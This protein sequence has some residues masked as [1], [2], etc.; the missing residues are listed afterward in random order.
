MQVFDAVEADVDGT[1]LDQAFDTLFATG[2]DKIT[3]APNIDGE[4]A[5]PIGSRCG[6]STH[7][8]DVGCGVKHR[9]DALAGGN[10]LLEVLY[11]TI[12]KAEIGV[13]QVQWCAA[14][15]RTH[16]VAFCQKC[17]NQ[18]AAGESRSACYQAN[19]Q[20]PGR[21]AFRFG[22]SRQPISRKQ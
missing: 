4:G 10:H 15:Q 2:L 22:Q 19:T 12:G 20:S 7:R 9:I 5:V 11:V 21:V 13:L 17:F 1:G 14:D 3:G 16:T 8:G 6:A 18:M